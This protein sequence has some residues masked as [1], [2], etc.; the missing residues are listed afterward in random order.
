MFTF[1]V[2]QLESGFPSLYS[3]YA[4]NILMNDMARHVPWQESE[5]CR[6]GLKLWT[7]SFER[8]ICSYTFKNWHVVYLIFRVSG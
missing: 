2:C 7:Y 4:V 1:D 8:Q 3:H 5:D 6:L